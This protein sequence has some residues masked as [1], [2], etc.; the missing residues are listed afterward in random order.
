MGSTGLKRG[1][2][3]PTTLSERSSCALVHGSV[4]VATLRTYH[5]SLGLFT[6]Q[7]LEVLASFT[8]LE[9]R[10]TPSEARRQFNAVNPIGPNAL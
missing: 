5:R 1:R 9:L 7:S 10:G 4:G 2:A 8:T 3:L 6:Q